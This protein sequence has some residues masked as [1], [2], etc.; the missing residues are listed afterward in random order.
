[1]LE[2]RIAQRRRRP[3]H[4]RQVDRD[5]AGRIGRRPA[6]HVLR[7]GHRVVVAQD[8]GQHLRLV[9]QVEP[10]AA[11][12][13]GGRQGGVEQVL[14]V[15]HAVAL[16]VGGV[17]RPGARQEL[18]RPHGARVG[19]P[20]AGGA[21]D[22]DLVAGQGAVQRRAVDRGD[23]GAARVDRAAA[24]VARF[25]APDPGQQVPA[26]AAA[27]GG[28][29]HLLLRI[30]VGGQRDTRNAKRPRRIDDRG[31]RRGG[32][33]RLG[34]VKGGGAAVDR[35]DGG[36]GEVGEGRRDGGHRGD[37]GVHRGRSHRQRRARRTDRTREDQGS[38]HGD[39]EYRLAR[40]PKCSLPHSRGGRVCTPASPY[41]HSTVLG[42]S[43][44]LLSVSSVNQITIHNSCD[45]SG[46]MV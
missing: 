38:D 27:R 22:D 42:V 15:G 11:Q 28:D 14:R 7:V 39:A 44:A 9:A 24:R 13:A 30:A 5:D 32:Q 36:T 17:A 16:A 10:A 31:R 8:R 46:A 41:A 3:G 20:V 12:V 1:M 19:D 43:W 40:V 35:D 6:Q 37:G 4:R 23:R 26:H 33:C 2:V 45:A 29:G 21:L 25:D 34:D 18:H